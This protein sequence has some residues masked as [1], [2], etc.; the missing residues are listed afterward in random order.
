MT[1]PLN[2]PRPRQGLSAVRRAEIAQ[3]GYNVG[4]GK[5]PRET[6]FKKGQSGNPTG[7]PRQARALKTDLLDVLDIEVA[8]SLPGGPE[9]MPMQRAMTLSLAAKAAKGDVR[10][11][12][13]IIRLIE[14]T[15]PERLKDTTDT[16]SLDPAEKI[17]LARLLGEMGLDAPCRKGAASPSTEDPD[18]DFDIV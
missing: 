18:D 6:Q 14:L 12:Q 1:E 17:M 11:A 15:A 5:P 4:F 7:R 13:A 3:A 16:Q 8:V 10:A 2:A 9:R